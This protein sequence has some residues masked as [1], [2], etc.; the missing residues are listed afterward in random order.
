MRHVFIVKSIKTLAPSRN[1]SHGEDG[2]LGGRRERGRPAEWRGRR[3]Q[4][5]C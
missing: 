2:E 4:R 1:F 3:V 5:V